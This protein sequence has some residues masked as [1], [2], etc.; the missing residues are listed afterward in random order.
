MGVSYFYNL[1]IVIN[2]F[3]HSMLHKEIGFKVGI[4]LSHQSDDTAEIFAA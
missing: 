3:C 2:T 1:Q 4:L